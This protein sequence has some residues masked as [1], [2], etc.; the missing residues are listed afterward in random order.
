MHSNHSMLGMRIQCYCLRLQLSPDPELPTTDCIFQLELVFPEERVT[1]IKNSN[2]MPIASSS[3]RLPV[4]LSDEV[5]GIASLTVRLK[6]E[7]IGR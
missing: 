4:S 2:N 3:R 7:I 6:L 1:L 5:Y